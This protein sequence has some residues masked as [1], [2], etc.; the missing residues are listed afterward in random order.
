MDDVQVRVSADATISVVALRYDAEC[1]CE[2]AASL[3]RRAGRA[4]LRA[5]ELREENRAVRAEASLARAR[6]RALRGRHG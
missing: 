2:V 3:C 1:N 4:R 6:A 5:Q